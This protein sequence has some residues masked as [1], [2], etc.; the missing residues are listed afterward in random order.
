LVFGE[1]HEWSELGHHVE[2]YDPSIW[3][4]VISGV[5]KACVLERREC[6]VQSHAKSKSSLKPGGVYLLT[7]DGMQN[8]KPMALI[9]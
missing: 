6:S 7:D 1:K 4:G 8:R 3:C 9:S 5:L 2:P